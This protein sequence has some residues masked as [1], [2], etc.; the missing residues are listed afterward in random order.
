M[1]V[2]VTGRTGIYELIT[3]NE[4]LRGMI[5]S[6]ENIQDIDSYLLPKTTT[7][8]EDG[9][10]RVLAGIERELAELE[11]TE[12]SSRTTAGPKQ[13][14][15]HA[16]IPTAPKPATPNFQADR[17]A[18][19]LGGTESNKGGFFNF[20]GKLFETVKNSFND[21]ISLFSKKT[22]IIPPVTSGVISRAP[23]VK[24][25]STATVIRRTT[26]TVE[27]IRELQVKRFRDMETSFQ[28]RREEVDR[29]SSFRPK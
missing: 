8:R 1:C 13:P 19:R 18:T 2:L 24:G 21:F 7:I 27:K 28:K 16:K 9:F 22:A 25:T 14:T 3:I 26:I 4:T 17:P 12:K 29:G 15:N 23:N 10:K 11:A 6:H 5:H 20:I